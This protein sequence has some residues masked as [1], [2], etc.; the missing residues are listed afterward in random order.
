[1]GTLLFLVIKHGGR[2]E[3]HLLIVKKEQRWI[4]EL[5]HIDSI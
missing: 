1:M 5:Y 4:D 3:R 2:R